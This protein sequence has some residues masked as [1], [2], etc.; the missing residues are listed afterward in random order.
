MACIVFGLAFIFAASAQSAM[1]FKVGE[2]A[3]IA[4]GGYM[5][6]LSGLRVGQEGRGKCATFR[7]T[8]V[9]EF[10][11]TFSPEAKLFAAGRFVREMGYELED[12]VRADMG[13]DPLPDDYYNETDFKAYELYLDVDL[14]RKLHV[15]TGRQFI[16]WGETDVFTLLDVI[17]PADSSWITP[18]VMPLEETRIPQY[19]ARVIY[20]ISPLT[21]LEFVF[22]PMIDDEDQ[23]VGKGAPDGGRMKPHPEDRIGNDKLYPNMM[24][25]IG[26]LMAE[27]G[28][29]PA[30]D[31]VAPSAKVMIPES[32][33]DQSRVG[34]RFTTTVGRVTMSF[35]DFY[36]HN[37]T[38]VVHY[39]GSIH[40][41]RREVVEGAGGNAIYQDVN[42]YI[43]KFSIR[44]KRQNIVGWA[45]NYFD[46]KFTNS[47]LRGEFAYYPNLPYNTFDSREKNA[48]TEK[49]TLKYCLGMDKEIFIPWLHPDDPNR[50]FFLSAQM[51]QDVI[52]A[53]DDDL[54]F[55]N[56]K[57]PIEKFT[58]KFTLKFNTGYFND[59]YKP[60]LVVAYDVAGNGLVKTLLTWK[61]PWNENYYVEFTYINYWGCQYEWLGMFKEKDS[62]FMRVRYMW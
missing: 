51:F 12:N 46:D 18:A 20:D 53:S 42:Y 44:Y 45:F 59:V 61:P 4:F 40:E 21:N 9:P 35:A 27:H 22:V 14:S 28:F 62:V 33:L 47:V 41:L 8:F 2:N 24:P 32:D 54:R 13:R 26:A 31:K 36:G 55:I 34:V 29:N 60:E 6:N 17:C 52:L 5:E 49:D 30:I 58:T 43:P 25:D 23:R 15:R 16:I 56:Y 7:S 19:A 39:D 3:E 37:Y 10:L 50:T 48:V 11:F 57:T 1:N 38:P